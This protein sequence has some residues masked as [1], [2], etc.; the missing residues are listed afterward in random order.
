MNICSINLLVDSNYFL[1]ITIKLWVSLLRTEYLVLCK[2]YL[3]FTAVLWRRTP[4]FLM[5]ELLL[6]SWWDWRLQG[7]LL[8]LYYLLRRLL[9][10][11]CLSHSCPN[12]PSCVRCSVHIFYL[13]LHSY[14]Y[15]SLPFQLALRRMMSGRLQR[16]HVWAEVS[17]ITK[18]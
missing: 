14:T 13:F 3:I 12:L 4:I 9:S 15:L 6:Q 7:Y 16:N 2:C 17:G 5:C 10:A 18:N 1:I 11:L 8:E